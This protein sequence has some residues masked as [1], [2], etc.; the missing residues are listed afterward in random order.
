[1]PSEVGALPA[2][3]PDFN[4]D[5]CR[6][7]LGQEEGTAKPPECLGTEKP[8]SK[9]RCFPGL[10]EMPGLGRSEKHPSLPEPFHRPDCRRAKK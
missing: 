1:M 9:R 7:G 6:L 2:Y 8:K 10:P 5:E 4:A 3:S